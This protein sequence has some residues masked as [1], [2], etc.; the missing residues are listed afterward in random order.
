LNGKCATVGKAKTGWLGLV[1][2]FM[3]SSSSRCLDI[4]GLSAGDGVNEA[5][6]EVRCKGIVAVFPSFSGKEFL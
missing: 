5:A 6:V 3:K 4:L 2:L 1:R